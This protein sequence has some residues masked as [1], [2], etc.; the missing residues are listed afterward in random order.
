[1]DERKAQLI[2]EAHEICQQRIKLLEQQQMDMAVKSTLVE[3]A[4]NKGE[5][6][7]A[8]HVLRSPVAGHNIIL[9][10]FVNLCI[11]AC[12]IVV[13]V[14]RMGCPFSLSTTDRVVRLL[15]NLFPS[16]PFATDAI[17]SL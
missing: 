11:C 8:A 6:V 12:M 17:L 10:L 2:A 16:L 13:D 15:P 5:R 9:Y 1:M 7:C 3:E 14:Y 4:L